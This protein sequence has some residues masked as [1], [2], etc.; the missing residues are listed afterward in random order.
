MFLKKSFNSFYKVLAPPKYEIHQLQAVN[1]KDNF[2]LR[3]LPLAVIQNKN[4]ILI[5]DSLQETIHYLITVSS[6]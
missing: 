4:H 2:V 5:N 1:F 3:L 6:A